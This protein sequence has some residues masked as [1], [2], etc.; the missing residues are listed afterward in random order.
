MANKFSITAIFSGR[1]GI[2]KVVAGIEG[3]VGRASTNI[4]SS[5]KEIDAANSKVVGG[6]AN[7]AKQA[8]AVGAV[9]GGGLAFGLEHII[10]A[11]A[12]FEQSI[13]NVGAVMGKSR[14]QIQDLEKEAMRLGV[15]TQF[16]SSE[17]AEA[18]S[19]WRAR[20]SIR[21]KFSR[22]SPAS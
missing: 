12:G 4:G 16:S 7:L 19:S 22:A 21:G 18:W 8:L 13:T 15:V 10:R 6:L 20:A 2:S 11:G 1:D 5:L 14:S 3:R 9:L 17:V